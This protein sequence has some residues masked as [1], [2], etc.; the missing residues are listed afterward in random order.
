[1]NLSCFYLASDQAEREGFRASCLPPVTLLPREAYYSRVAVHRQVAQIL[2]LLN[3]CVESIEH[4]P[5]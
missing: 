5:T 3:N 1:M 2:T 4:I